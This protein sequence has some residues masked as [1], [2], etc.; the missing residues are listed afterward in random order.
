MQ[1]EQVIEMA[2]K[3]P[4]RKYFTYLVRVS[5]TDL[6]EGSWWF[7][8]GSILSVLIPIFPLISLYTGW[9]PDPTPFMPKDIHLTCYCLLI[10]MG[11]FFTIG[12]YM[13]LRAVHPRDKILPLLPSVFVTDELFGMFTFFVGILIC[14][15]MTAMYAA[16]SPTLY[17]RGAVV[18]SI[19]FTL[20]MGA[21]C[22]VLWRDAVQLTKPAALSEEKEQGAKKRGCIVPLLE[23]ICG[24]K[25]DHYSSDLLILSWM[26]LAGNIMAVM[27]C[28]GMLIDAC[29]AG[30]NGR[31]IFDYA[32]GLA[33]ILIFLIGSIYFTS[34]FYEDQLLQSQR[35]GQAWS[36]KLGSTSKISSAST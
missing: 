36:T 11:I 26:S 14:I 9:W 12:S 23:C 27:M 25:S 17:F 20:L 21:A 34:G 8:W 19:F 24:G 4:E 13:F 31:D 29:R 3:S 6:V 16:Y 22:L 33:D 30:K 32:T 2:S 15:P 18:V 35:L 5:T 1:P 7:V 28:A 10:I